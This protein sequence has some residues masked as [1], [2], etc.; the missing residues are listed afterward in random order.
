MPNIELAQLL[1]CRIERGFVSVDERQQ[2]SVEGIYCVGEATGIG[3]VDKAQVE[4]SIAGLAASGQMESAKRLLPARNREMRLVRSLA[5]TFRLREELRT[6]A[7]AETLVCRCEDVAYGAVAAACRGVRPSC[8]H[9]A[10]WVPARGGY[11]GRRPR[12]C[13]DGKRHPRGRRCF[14]PVSAL[15]PPPVKIPPPLPGR[16]APSP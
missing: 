2:T 7:E 16:S 5:H 14:P 12:F 4:G 8:I 15:L 1:Q 11:A 13:S 3:G 6:L 9:A 10:E